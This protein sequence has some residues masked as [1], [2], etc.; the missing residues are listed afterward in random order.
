[1]SCQ[2]ISRSLNQAKRK[3]EIRKKEKQNR[4][5]S[6]RAEPKIGENE[7]QNWRDS[8]RVEFNFFDTTKYQHYST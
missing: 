2:S 8:H 7:K 1:M 4:T 5:D 3:K 6:H